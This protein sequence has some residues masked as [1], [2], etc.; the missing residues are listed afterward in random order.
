MKKLLAVLLALMVVGGAAFAQ[1]APKPVFT[2]GAYAD[3]EAD[4]INNDGKTASS[5]YTETYFGFKAA[6]MAFNA[7]TVGGY[8]I[9]KEVR[10]YALSYTMLD[11]MLKVYGGKLRE[12]GGVRLASYID[13]NGFSTRLGNVKEGVMLTVKP[14]ADFTFSAFLPVWGNLVG[15]DYAKANIGVAYNL[16]ELMNVVAGYRLENKELYASFDVKAIPDVTLR[17]GYRMVAPATAGASTNYVY[18]TGGTTM[19]ALEVGLDADVSLGTVMNF[20]A[21]ALVAYKVAETTTAGV[22][23]S[24]DNGDAW[25]GNDGINVNPFVQQDFA[26]GD[27]KVGFSFT[28]SGGTSSWYLPI[29]FELSF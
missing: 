10:N 17:L 19:D 14:I 3:Y 24:F 16:P 11:G 8:D 9:F 22:K 29:E 15:T 28:T 7:T 27:I 23:V 25:Y 12:T 20:G 4:L 5:I 1:D 13:G 21:K 26:N 6:D 2:V 18:V